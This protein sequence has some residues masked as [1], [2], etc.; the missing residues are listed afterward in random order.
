[1]TQ[2][3]LNLLLFLLSFSSSAFA[4][5]VGFEDQI[6]QNFK[7]SKPQELALSTDYYKEGTKSLEWNFTPG[8]VIDV[9]V[10]KS[11]A[12]KDDNGI[13]LWIYNER[14]QKDSLRFEF[15]A[16]NGDVS[17]RFAFRLYSAG[18]RACWIGF[19]NMQGDKKNHNVA[20]YRI[21]AP[22]RKGRVYLDRLTFPVKK[23]NDRT[24]PDLQMP[25]NNS[26]SYRDLWHWCRVWQWELYKYDIPLAKQ[27]TADE[28]QDL[29]TVEKRLTEALDVRVA[30]KK[31]VEKAYAT[32]KKV[33]TTATETTLTVTCQHGQPV[34]FY[35]IK[36]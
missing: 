11:F 30:P 34:E 18:W 20:G 31:Q 2:K 35:I 9:A 1:M 21:I 3:I 33:Q 19:K 10:E 13:M 5:L 4:Q 16:P 15:Y 7:C 14:P 22:E 36:G 25:S 27:L 12:L 29:A 28:K 32:F 24:T 8:S 23:I 17:Y 26:L 6:P